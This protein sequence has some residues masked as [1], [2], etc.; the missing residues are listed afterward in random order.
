MDYGYRVHGNHDPQGEL[1]PAALSMDSWYEP[2]YSKED[3]KFE[4]PAMLN[5][6]LAVRGLTRGAAY[7]LLRYDSVA[8]VPPRAFLQAGGWSRRDDFRAVA[9]TREVRVSF[10]SNTTIFFRCVAVE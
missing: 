2:D 6:T 9:A 7:A 10:W 4:K 3:A 1:Q 5:G 8:A